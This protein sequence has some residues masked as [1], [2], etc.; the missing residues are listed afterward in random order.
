M[1]TFTLKY[2]IIKLVLEVIFMGF[3]ENLK[4]KEPN[5]KRMM[6]EIEAKK[7]RNVPPRN[8]RTMKEIEAKKL[9]N[10]PPRNTRTMKEIEAKKLRNNPEKDAE[11]R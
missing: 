8:T 6:E 2:D 3:R 4:V 1:L 5:N 10:V 9:R 7:L 11:E